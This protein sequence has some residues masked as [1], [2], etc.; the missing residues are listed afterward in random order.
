MR[1]AP[2]STNTFPPTAPRK[3]PVDGT[4]GVIRQLG[5]ARVSEMIAAS[6]AVDAVLTI[7]SARNAATLL[8]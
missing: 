3:N 1:R 7:A 5:Y 2:R 6:D 8:R 4:A